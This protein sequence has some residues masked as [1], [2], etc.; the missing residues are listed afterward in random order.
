MDAIRA[1]AVGLAGWLLTAPAAAQTA[2]PDHPIR[3][4]VI[5]LRRLAIGPEH[6]EARQ[7]RRHPAFDIAG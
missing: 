6:D 3:F 1:L 7:R 4:I 2:Y 5:E